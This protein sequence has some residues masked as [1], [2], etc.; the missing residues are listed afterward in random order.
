V[1]ALPDRAQTPADPGTAYQLGKI[2]GQLRELIHQQNNEAMKNTAR[3]EKLAKLEGV[4]K[5]IE[6]IKIEMATLKTD[7][8]RRDGAFN[9]G[10]ALIRS[11]LVVWLAVAALAVWTWLRGHGQ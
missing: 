10:G 11:P 4:P 3:D 8:D 5:D 9:F 7:K 6:E 1:T 2:E